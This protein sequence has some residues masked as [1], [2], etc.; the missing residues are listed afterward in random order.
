[1]AQPK[2]KGTMDQVNKALADGG[3]IGKFTEVTITDNRYDAADLLAL[4]TTD[5]GLLQPIILERT[6]AYSELSE[7]EDNLI[8]ILNGVKKYTGPVDVDGDAAAAKLN[9]IAGLTTGKV[10]A[11]L[12]AATVVSSAT[13]KALSNVNSK[14]D[15]EFE[16]TD[17]LANDDAISALVSLNKI[18]KSADFSGITAMAGTSTNIKDIKSAQALV[19]KDATVAITG[20]ISAKDAN[21]ISPKIKHAKFFYN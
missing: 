7:D 8:I 13:V 3:I 4:I 1:M 16:P 21:D 20:E 19:D 17:P 5:G 15:I 10:T 11:T 14:D 9:T 6:S 12:D 18:L 2:F